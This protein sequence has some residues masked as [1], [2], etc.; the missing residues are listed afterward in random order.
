MSSLV[1]AS[2]ALLI[3]AVPG[4]TLAQAD[5]PT[6]TQAIVSRGE[7]VIKRAPDRAWLSVAT[8]VRAGRAPDARTQ[9]AQIVTALTAALKGAGLA[10]DAI[11]TTGYSL[12]PEMDWNNG[13]GTVRGYVVRNTLE[14]RVDD[15]DK[16]GDVIDAANSPKDAGLSITGPRFDLKN[17]VA[18]EQDALKAAVDSAM[19]RAEAM[20]A[21]ARRSLGPIIRVELEHVSPSGP[22][23]RP[24]MAE[25]TMMMSDKA[26]ETPITPGEIEIRA[27]VV[28]TLGIQ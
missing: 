16:L 9:S 27:S 20:A 3:L 12:M 23:P 21:G 15:L 4:T 6:Q 13:R 24:M 22:G 17:L 8:E 11:R 26:V 18:A 2:L 25:R 7:G 5:R 19:R 10:D 1:A 28:V 14:V